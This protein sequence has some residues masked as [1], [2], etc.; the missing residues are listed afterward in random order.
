MI[1]CFRN[2]LVEGRLIKQIIIG[3]KVSEKGRDGETRT[4]GGSA[5]GWEPGLFHG[6]SRKKGNRIGG[7]KMR[8]SFSICCCFPPPPPAPNIYQL[9]AL[10][11][12]EG[13]T[14]YGDLKR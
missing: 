13:G 12:S 8:D 7:G 11:E 3:K 4:E 1:L 6:S 2:E 5:T 14:Q 10:F 9:R